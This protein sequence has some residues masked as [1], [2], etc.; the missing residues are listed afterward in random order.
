MRKFILGA[1]LAVGIAVDANAARP[2]GS[3]PSV[4]TWGNQICT[5]GSGRAATIQGSI[6]N[7][8]IGP[9]PLVDN[10]GI[11]VCQSF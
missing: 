2:I 4:D 9:H 5:F 11:R 1:I 3:F 10:W 7:C 8:S 6:Q